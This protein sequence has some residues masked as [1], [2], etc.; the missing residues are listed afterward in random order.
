MKVRFLFFIAPVFAL[1]MMASC[2]REY[3]CQCWISYSGAPGLP[4]S[5]LHE[6]PIRDKKK[7]AEKLCK[8]NSYHTEQNG[9]TTTEECDLY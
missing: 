3:T 8:D 2:T 9:I 1:L 6:Y 4:D 5:V 7:N